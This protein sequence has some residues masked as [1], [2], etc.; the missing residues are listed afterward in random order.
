M[1][2]IDLKQLNEIVQPTQSKIIFLVVD[3]LGGLPHPDSGKSELETSHLPNLDRIAKDS[4]CGLTTPVLPGITP[5]SGPGHLSLFGYDPLKYE[6]GRGVLEALGIGVNLNPDDVAIRGNFCT[7]DRDGLLID[8]RAG[9]I[10]TDQSLLLCQKLN[11]I[12]I[13]DISLTVYPVQDH[14]FVLVMNGQNLSDEVT[15]TDPQM[16]GVSPRDATAITS[17]AKKTAN[18]VNAFIMQASKLLQNEDQANMVLLRGFSQ[19]PTLPDINSAYGLNSAA[20]AAY[21]MYRGLAQLLGMQVIQTG[22][23]FP[24]EVLTLSENYHNHNFFFLHYKPADAAGEDGNFSEKVE[25]LEQLDAIVPQILDLNPDVF[26]IAGD[27]STPAVMA[28]HSWHEVPFL[29]HSQWTI[30]DGVEEFTERAC[31]HGSIGRIPASTAM[32]LTLAHAGKL[33]KYG[34]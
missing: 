15:E 20:I 29:I 23:S 28:S 34:P 30:G 4:A 16:L 33:S 9:R 32:L 19:L 3:G 31:Q 10:P 21:P 26:V 11:G 25:A 8:R 17:R 14:R 2:L 27:H 12:E 13:D 18:S 24:Q 22:T 5:G 7:V 1:L 6:I